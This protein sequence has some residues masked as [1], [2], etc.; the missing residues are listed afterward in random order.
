MTVHI[1]FTTF[2]V[3]APEGLFGVVC[4]CWKVAK[5]WWFRFEQNKCEP[6]V[7]ALDPT[8]PPLPA[9][10]SHPIGIDQMPLCGGLHGIQLF[11]I[12]RLPSWLNVEAGC[13]SPSSFGRS[14]DDRN[15]M[16]TF[17]DD[18]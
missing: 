15:L 10:S 3:W 7:F 2:A 14:Q 13:V 16:V 1:H 17:E 4:G 12:D 18:S 5:A 11:L 8:S 9:S 6:Q